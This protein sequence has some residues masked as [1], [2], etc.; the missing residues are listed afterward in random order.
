MRLWLLGLT[1]CA[2]LGCASP[3]PEERGQVWCEHEDWWSTPHSLDT[4]EGG[5]LDLDLIGG[6]D[7]REA[8][9]VAA[10]AAALE[11]GRRRNAGLLEHVAASLPRCQSDYYQERLPDAPLWNPRV[12]EEQQEAIEGAY[13][14]LLSAYQGPL[15]QDLERAHPGVWPRLADLIRLGRRQASEVAWRALGESAR[16]GKRI[17]TT[18]RKAERVREDM[19]QLLFSFDSGKVSQSTVERFL[20]DA[21]FKELI[22]ALRRIWRLGGR[23]ARPVAR[24]LKTWR[25]RALVRSEDPGESIGDLARG[26]ERYR[27]RALDAAL[28]ATLAAEGARP[29]GK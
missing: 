29:E 12:W 15:V 28:D 22:D 13:G 17:R 14:Q 23:D 26:A 2:S 27:D 18:F 7:P 9:L 24:A 11:A 5:D 4:G 19:T 6:D 25:R 8:K 20:S 16:R 3:S 21:G 10:Y 1:V